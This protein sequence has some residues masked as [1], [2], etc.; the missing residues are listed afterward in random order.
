M[1]VMAFLQ[2]QSRDDSCQ[3]RVRL[4]HRQRARRHQ[5]ATWIP[6]EYLHCPPF[7]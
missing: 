6:T 1:L 2:S 4:T 5:C 3:E 7:S